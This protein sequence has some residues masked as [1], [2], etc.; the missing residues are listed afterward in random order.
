MSY[1]ACDAC[2]RLFVLSLRPDALQA[3]PACRGPVRVISEEESRTFFDPIPLSTSY[4][5]PDIPAIPETITAP[6]VGA[7]SPVSGRPMGCSAWVG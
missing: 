4:P 1:I 2:L 5:L 3:C 7:S 6:G